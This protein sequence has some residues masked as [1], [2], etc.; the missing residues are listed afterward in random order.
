MR[1]KI[2]SRH[3]V[4]LAELI[5]LPDVE[6]ASLRAALAEAQPTTAPTVLAR[7]VA[8]A[9]N[10]D[11]KR[12]ER[13]VDALIALIRARDRQEFSTERVAKDV[14]EALSEEKVGDVE[15]NPERARAFEPQ[16]REL[17]DLDQSLGI[18]SRALTVL[19][20]HKHIYQSAR[21]LTDVR[22]VFSRGDAPSPVAG[23]IVHNLEIETVTDGEPLRFFVALDT[24]DVRALAQVIE[25]AVR[26]EEALRSVIQKTNLPYVDVV[27]SPE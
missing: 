1:I 5:S 13:I 12:V 24:Q 25:R 19:N 27:P 2:P 3:T 14:T 7:R 8:A 20:Q 22:A 26:K 15:P 4:A 17:L 16:L 9:T 23:M 18:T 21:I 6:F 11:T 10:I